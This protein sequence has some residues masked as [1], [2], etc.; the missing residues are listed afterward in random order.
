MHGTRPRTVAAPRRSG[1][2]AGPRRASNGV[3]PAARAASA[4]ATC[5][6]GTSFSTRYCST[7]EV[8]AARS[9]WAMLAVI[10][11]WKRA[12]RR[13]LMTSVEGISID[14]IVCRV[15]CSIRLQEVSP[16]GMEEEDRVAATT[17]PARPADPVD[18]A[19]AVGREVVVD[20]MADPLHVQAAGGHVGGDDHVDL[21]RSQV[22]DDPLALA[23]R[24]IAAE[25][26]RAMPLAGEVFGERLGRALGI[27]EDQDAL[28][29]FGLQDPGEHVFLLMRI[30]DDEALT[31]GVGRRGLLLDGDLGRV[32]Q[33]ALG[34]PADRVGHGGR[35]QRDLPLGRGLGEDP[36]DV[37]G[38]A[39]LEHLVGLVQDQ[40]A[41]RRRA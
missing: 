32:L 25:R 3:S 24:D 10:R 28:D 29:R 36:V 15:A 22:L 20:D 6:R 9:G 26:G 14:S 35:E 38:E 33:V 8:K 39:H 7:S 34:D 2:P 1:P 12:T 4:A 5:S 21:A 19:L 37:L 18:V 17:G 40:A 27:D 41:E 13:R 16:A 30:D 31:D 11:S 23:L